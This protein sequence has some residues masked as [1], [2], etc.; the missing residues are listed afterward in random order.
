MKESNK[1]AF[2]FTVKI[3][4]ENGTSKAYLLYTVLQSKFKSQTVRRVEWGSYK[5]RSGVLGYAITM[6]DIVR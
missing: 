1:N 5:L 2:V 3:S 6:C 4:A